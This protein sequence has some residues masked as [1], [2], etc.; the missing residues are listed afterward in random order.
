MDAGALSVAESVGALRRAPQV[1]AV[2]DPV[3][4]TPS[5]FSLALRD[6]RESAHDDGDTRHEDSFVRGTGAAGADPVVDQ[7]LPSQWG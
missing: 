5:A 4:Q 6:E 1:V 2:G 3:A 7:E